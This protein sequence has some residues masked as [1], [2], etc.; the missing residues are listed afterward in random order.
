MTFDFLVICTGFGYEKPIRDE[1]SIHLGDR[2]KSLDEIY[3]KV[4]DAPSVLIAGGGYV[5][6]EI[7]AEIAVKYGKEKKVGLCVRGSKLLSN[8]PP[9]FSEVAVDFLKSQN[10]TLHFNTLYNE[11]TTKNLGYELTI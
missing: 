11:D 8:L 3:Q 4:K 10:V 6:V 5:G 1:K 2:A 7:A 9:R